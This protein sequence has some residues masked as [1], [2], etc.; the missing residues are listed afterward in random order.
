MKWRAANRLQLVWTAN[1]SRLIGAAVS[2]A[3]LAA[4]FSGLIV[5]GP[6]RGYAT[7]P[8]PA[9]MVGDFST[10][11][12]APPFGSTRPVN[13]ES[14]VQSGD[15]RGSSSSSRPGRGRQPDAQV[16]NLPPQPSE[17]RRP[18]PPRS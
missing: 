5:A 13:D 4:I 12:T 7:A 16:D 14:R 8:R 17:G 1:R 10:T 18:R 9:I 6:G 3:A 2:V 11:T 15:G